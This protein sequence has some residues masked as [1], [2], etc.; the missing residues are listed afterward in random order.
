VHEARKVN[1]FEYLAD[2]LAP[3]QEHPTS[4]IDELLQAHGRL[5]ATTP[6]SGR[7]DT[8]D[9]TVTQV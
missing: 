7:H 3:V 8:V 4:A 1:P 5:P 6:K 2:V 9:R